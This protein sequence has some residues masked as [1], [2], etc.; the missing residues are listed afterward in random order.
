MKLEDYIL[1]FENLSQ[2]KVTKRFNSFEEAFELFCELYE[3]GY[4]SIDIQDNLI[5]IHTGGWSENEQLI[6]ILKQTSFWV[7]F[8]KITT[9]GGHY[10]FDKDLWNTKLKH[11]KI[12]AE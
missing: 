1:D 9:T 11:W 4:G 6:S 7:K 10:Y 12:K 2:E 8:H 3:T 5:A